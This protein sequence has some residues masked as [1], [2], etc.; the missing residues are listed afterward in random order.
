[1]SKI[2]QRLTASMDAVLEEICGA[3][4][5]GGDH[6]TRKHIA[7]KLISSARKGNTTLE[8]LRTVARGA[9]EDLLRKSA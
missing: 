6:E 4:P 5:H 8:G 2:N 7:Q 1:M 9:L 3:L